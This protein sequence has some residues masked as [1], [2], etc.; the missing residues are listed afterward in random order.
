MNAAKEMLEHTDKKSYVIAG[1]A[2]YKNANYFSA[3]FKKYT[4]LSPKEYR[5]RSK[6]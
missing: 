4:G 2:G 3:M 5:E 6:A 1:E